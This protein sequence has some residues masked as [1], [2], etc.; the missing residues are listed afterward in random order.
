MRCGLLN[1]L[2]TRSFGCSELGPYRGPSTTA[3]RAYAQ[4]DNL[5]WAT[6]F[7]NAVASF[8]SPGEF[9]VLAVLRSSR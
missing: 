2:E 3:L 6:W 7:R 8:G 9:G 4:D 1:R 5:I